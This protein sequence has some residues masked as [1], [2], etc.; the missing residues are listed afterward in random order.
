MYKRAFRA[1]NLNLGYANTRIDPKN[2]TGF[3]DNR[4]QDNVQAHECGHLFAFPDEYWQ[5]EG[6]VHKTYVRDQQLIFGFGEILRGKPIW[7]IECADN[8]M[9]AAA[10]N[11]APVSGRQQTARI[12]PYYLEYVRREFSRITARPWKIGYE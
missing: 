5:R 10:N 8:L 11:S 9:G 7:Q 4:D 12:E 3:R 2:T 6:S 1:N